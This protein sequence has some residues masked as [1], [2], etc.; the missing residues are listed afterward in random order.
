MAS[1]YKILLFL[2][3]AL[4]HGKR[5]LLWVWR[6]VTLVG[7]RLEHAF[8]N[9][10]GFRLYKVFFSAK[11]HAMRAVPVFSVSGLP[12]FIGKRA[13]LQAVFF[14]VA[15]FLMIPHTRLAAQ[16]AAS[17]PG[18]RTIMYALVGPGDVDFDTEEIEVEPAIV[19]PSEPSW[20]TGV[21]TPEAPGGAGISAGISQGI[22]GISAGGTALT[23]PVILPGSQLPSGPSTAKRTQVVLHTVSSGEIIGSIAERYGVAVETIL[24]ANN[25]TLRSR[26][27][28]GDTLKI[29]PSD[30]AIHTVKR[31]DT[32]GKIAK[33]YGAKET[34]IVSFNKL[35]SDGSDIVVGEELFI[36]GGTAPKPP[37]PKPRPAERR[38]T[39]L[40]NIAAP[41]PSVAA[42]AGSGYIWPAGVR[43]ISQ[44]FTLRHNGVDI[45]GPVGT[46][47][48]AARSGTVVKSQCGWNGGYGCYVILDHGDGYRTLYGHAARLFV[49]P[50]D[51]VNQGQTIAVMGSTGNSTGPHVHFE[52]RFNNKNQ[53]PLRFVR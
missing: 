9:T 21:V 49:N 14:L 38:Y 43:Y 42:P 29:L 53:N 52:V 20:K 48:Y 50:G 30:G 8:Q 2:L 45:A 46:P 44:Y 25:L 5:A 34:D 24:T 31:G 40:S 39:V 6:R 15:F 27:H 41:P 51:S 12:E 16:D 11:R 32:V 35:R 18:R 7:A 33:L 37:A 17:F 13:T 3:R 47:L 22:S 23:K 36:P 19:A 10:I 26:I 28:P 4:V 1:S